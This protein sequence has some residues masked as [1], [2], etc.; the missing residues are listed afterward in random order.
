MLESH[1]FTKQSIIGYKS[2]PDI[3]NALL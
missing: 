3:F 2:G 1:I